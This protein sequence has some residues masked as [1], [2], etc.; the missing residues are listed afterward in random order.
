[1]CSAPLKGLG[2]DLT[3]QCCNVSDTYNTLQNFL[4]HLVQAQMLCKPTRSPSY[5]MIL[6]VFV[7]YYATGQGP[8][9]WHTAQSPV[10]S[11]LSHS[12]WHR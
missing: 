8:S 1:M 4:K 6:E 10:L 11:V 2:I 5:Q 12:D 3:Y 7:D 9:G